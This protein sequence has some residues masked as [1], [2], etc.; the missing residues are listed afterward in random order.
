MYASIQKFLQFQLTVNI[1]AV[2][3]AL[4][5][6]VVY[7]RS[8]LAAIQL[9]WVNLLMDSLASLALAS[10]P[11]SLE[12]LKNPP[13]NRSENMITNQM[14]A[15]MLGQSFYQVLIT[16]LLL[17]FGPTWFD[18]EAGDIV[19]ARSENSVH[20]TLIFNSF[21]WMQLFNELNARNLSGE[22]NVFKGL[23]KNPIFCTILVVTSCLQC[24]MVEFGG[25][26]MH[27]HE[28]G[29]ETKYWILS[30]GF[31]FF[32]LIWQ[33]LINLLFKLLHSKYGYFK[34]GYERS[35]ASRRHFISLE[36]D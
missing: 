5:G 3:T 16:M 19:E 25:K 32:S 23:Q 22:T 9:L 1:S 26:A 21:V 2:V 27:V 11:P 29:L 15:N 28:N 20:Y 33:Q 10:E 31:G 8:P 4:V 34:S 14:W 13:I 18:I 17:F 36:N 7:Q 30:L 24:I 35:E 12:L 6:A